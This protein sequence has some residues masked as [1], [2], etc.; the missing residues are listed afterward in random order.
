MHKETRVKKTMAEEERNDQ[1]GSIHLSV[2]VN[3]EDIKAS[4]EFVF[5]VFDVRPKSRPTILS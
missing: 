5:L 4:E 1:N 2:V 3:D